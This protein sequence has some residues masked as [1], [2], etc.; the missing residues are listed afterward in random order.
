MTNFGN[1]IR[2]HFPNGKTPKFP[3]QYPITSSSLTLPA[4]FL[5]SHFLPSNHTRISYTY[6]CTCGFPNQLYDEDTNACPP[7]GC[8][9]KKIDTWS[10]Q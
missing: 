7:L 2:L 4:I 10:Y 6:S 5:N 8:A 3:P 1:H 9:L